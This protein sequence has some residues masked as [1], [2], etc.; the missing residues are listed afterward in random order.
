LCSYGDVQ[1]KYL[2]GSWLCAGRGTVKKDCARG[3]ALLVEAAT[4]GHARACYSLGVMY[5][6]GVSEGDS[7]SGSSEESVVVKIDLAAAAV[8][9]EKA[10]GLGECVKECVSSQLIILS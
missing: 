10:S 9:F 3:T 7:N 8:W 1:A 6:E 5:L 4:A 2:Q